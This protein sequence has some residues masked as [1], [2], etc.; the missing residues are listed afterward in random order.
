[1][2]KRPPYIKDG[3]GF[4]PLTQG[5]TAI[6]DIDDYAEISKF[7]WHFQ[8]SGGVGYAARQATVD[9]RPTKQRQFI[10]MHH[11]IIGKHETMVVDHIN[12]NG[13]DNRKSN[14][15]HA[16]CSQ[17]QLNRKIT[18]VGKSGFRGVYPHDGKWQSRLKINGKSHHLGTF[19][20]V[21]LAAKAYISASIEMAGEYSR[22]YP[23]IRAGEPA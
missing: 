18:S 4:V 19:E 17:N 5:F 21:E 12:G 15:R 7:N 11:V 3:L 20:T 10:W 6:I 9:E 16:T 2:T 8:E 14:L 23:A 13:V 1:M 22:H